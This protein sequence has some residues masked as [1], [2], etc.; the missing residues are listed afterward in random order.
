MPSTMRSTTS[1]ENGQKF[2]ENTEKIMLS[3]AKTKALRF[4]RN[5]PLFRRDGVDGREISDRSGD[6]SETCQHC[7]YFDGWQCKRRSPYQS[8]YEVRTVNGMENRYKT[9]W[10]SVEKGNWCGE[11]QKIKHSTPKDGVTDIA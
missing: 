4:F 11:F 7:Q 6:D 2:A 3:E 10:P 1:P 8:T 9:H 5:I